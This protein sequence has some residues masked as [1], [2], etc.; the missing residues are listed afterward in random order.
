MYVNNLETM[1]FLQKIKNSV[2]NPEF[3]QEAMGKPFSFSL[4]YFLPTVISFKATSTGDVCL[5]FAA[6]SG[7]DV[8]MN[9]N[10]SD[11][12]IT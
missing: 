10:D 11:K 8:T 2:Y 1:N 12:L 6:T 9:Q 3:Y 7:S 5:R 4:K